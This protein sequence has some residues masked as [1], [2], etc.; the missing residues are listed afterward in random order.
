MF[1][2]HLCPALILCKSSLMVATIGG[3]IV[4]LLR[5]SVD[6]NGSS[7]MSMSADLTNNH[8]KISRRSVIHRPPP[9]LLILMTTF[10]SRSAR[11]P[12]FIAEVGLRTSEIRVCVT[13]HCNV[14]KRCPPPRRMRMEGNPGRRSQSLAIAAPREYI[15]EPPAFTG[16]LLP[17]RLEK[18]A[19]NLQRAVCYNTPAC[20]SLDRPCDLKYT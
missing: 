2:R 10:H 20:K 7:R 15:V 16:T 5:S 13:C 14:R 1:R 8:F 3:S 9:P 19:R 17:K 6:S 18:V 11:S 12:L 4:A